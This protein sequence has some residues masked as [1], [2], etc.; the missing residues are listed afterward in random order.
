MPSGILLCG[1]FRSPDS[2]RPA[3]MPVN[4]GKQVAK[5]VPKLSPP[6]MRAVMFNPAGRIAAGPSPRRERDD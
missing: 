6:L 3:I 5:T 1:F 2:P 4:A